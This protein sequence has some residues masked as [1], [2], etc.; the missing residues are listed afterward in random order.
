MLASAVTGQRPCPSTCFVRARGLATYPVALLPAVRDGVLLSMPAIARYA[1]V[2]RASTC[3]TA[4]WRQREPAGTGDL[5]RQP[6]RGPNPPGG[7]NRVPPDAR[8]IRRPGGRWN[9]CLD[10]VPPLVAGALPRLCGPRQRPGSGY[11]SRQGSIRGTK[12]ILPW[13]PCLSG[14]P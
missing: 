4:E 8:S 10:R 6:L 9:P 1:I 2:C 3:A 7:G 5:H 11:G 12:T 13:P 14:S